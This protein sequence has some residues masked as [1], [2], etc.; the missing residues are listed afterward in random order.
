MSSWPAGRDALRD[1]WSRPRS[2]QAVILVL[3]VWLTL[4]ANVALWRTLLAARPGSAGLLLCLLVGLIVF[5]GTAALLSLF[6][7]GRWSKPLW[8]A[9]AL[10][11]ALSQYYM[12]EFGVVID[13]TMLANIFQTDPREVRDLLTW[14]L[15]GHV[16]GVMA[17]PLLWLWQVPL[18]RQAPWHSALRSTALFGLALGGGIAIVAAAYSVLAPLV[19]NN[20]QLRYQPNPTMPVATLVKLATSP[21]LKPSRPLVRISEGAGLGS[22]HEAGSKPRLVVV[23]VGE[24]ARA[25]HFGLNGYARPTTPELAARDVF[26]F[27]NVW[28]CGTNTLASVPCMFSALGREG[29]GK[30]SAEHENL[31]DVA[32]AAGLAVLWI[33]NQAGCKGVC[34]R[35]P[36]VSTAD[37]AG[38]TEGQALCHDDECLD[39]ALLVGID[40]RLERL[41]ADRQRN[42]TLVVMHMMGSHGPAYS[43]RS[44]AEF[45]RF[46]PEC[47]STVLGE[48]VHDE[49]VNVYDNSIVY[50]DHV[51]AKTIDWLQTR[52]STEDTA[53]LYVSDHGESLGEYG[54]FLH[55]LPYALAP[56]AQKRVPMV[57]WLSGA[58]TQ[59]D[60]IDAACLRGQRDERLSHDNLFHSALGL[61]DVTSPRYDARLDFVASCRKPRAERAPISATADKR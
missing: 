17:L 2:A 56:D 43:R 1:A 38:S 14:T 49:L 31:L 23:V 41:P 45:K 28:S 47:L 53:L 10:A 19:R 42:G 9:V 13:R 60:G 34:A 16:L 11:A 44:T 35:V 24:T 7:W 52:S 26:S 54:I 15:L 33:D 4:F 57:V 37:L 32:N 30:R 25:D 55:G 12:V 40:G 59:R 27:G 46:R 36:N 58:L 51:L 8:L 6:G 20:M 21:L 22:T 29:Y 3:A 48:C 61:I 5:A 50:T 39:A 18:R